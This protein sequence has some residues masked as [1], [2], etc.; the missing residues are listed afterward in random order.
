[1]LCDTDV[2]TVTVRGRMNAGPNRLTAYAKDNQI[3][4]V[5][6]DADVSFPIHE[7]MND[8]FTNLEANGNLQGFRITARWNSA[9]VVRID[10]IDRP[11]FW[12][13]VD[14]T[15]FLAQEHVGADHDHHHPYPDPFPEDDD[16]CEDLLAYFL[17]DTANLSQALQEMNIEYEQAVYW[18]NLKYR[19]VTSYGE[20]VLFRLN[21]IDNDD[22]YE[23]CV[24]P[25]D[26]CGG[27]YDDTVIAS[28]GG[29]GHGH[30]GP[31]L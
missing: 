20:G 3:V 5:G 13:E 30:G 14:M 8:V 31:G 12:V 28:T 6:D 26:Y 21:N 24:P 17:H 25:R 9:Q 19:H 2:M 23:G 18:L 16:E 11:A 1:M 10:C 22:D 7:A 29:A 4:V 27:F 15:P